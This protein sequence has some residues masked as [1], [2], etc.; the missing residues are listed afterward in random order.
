MLSDVLHR[1]RSICYRPSITGAVRNC[2]MMMMM[3]MMIMMIM[4]G[5]ILYMLFGIQRNEVRALNT[6]ALYTRFIKSNQVIECNCLTQSLI[7]NCVFTRNNIRL[8]HLR[9]Q[10]IWFLT[11]PTCEVTLAVVYF[12]KYPGTWYSGSLLRYLGN[13]M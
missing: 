1:L 5:R 12:G 6:M 2:K 8:T 13:L 11:A 10:R 3:M 9:T 7:R 4:L